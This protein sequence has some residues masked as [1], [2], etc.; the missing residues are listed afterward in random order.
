MTKK[1]F[2]ISALYIRTALVL[3]VLCVI[4]GLTSSLSY[5]TSLSIS[6][7][8]GLK[9]MRP[10]HVTFAILWIMIA[11]QGGIYKALECNYNFKSKSCKVK[12]L[13]VN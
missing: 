12:P 6:S 4:A 8:F 10:L 5:V 1:P 2:D 7:Y 13:N 3:L 9:S 11:A